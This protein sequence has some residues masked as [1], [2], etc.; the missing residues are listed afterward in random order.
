MPSTE[1]IEAFLTHKLSLL[2]DQREES[3]FRRNIV[4]SKISK[5]RTLEQFE[6]AGEM[7]EVSKDTK[8]IDTTKE[9][10]DPHALIQEFPNHTLIDGYSI[11]VQAYDSYSTST[12]QFEISLKTLKPQKVILLEPTLEFMRALE[13]YNAEQNLK[14]KLD[15]LKEPIEI[16][17]IRY[18]ESTEMYQ[19]MSVIEQEK[20]GFVELIDMKKKLFVELKDYKLEAEQKRIEETLKKQ[21]GGR[22][23]DA[24]QETKE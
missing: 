12:E 11:Y 18:E 15:H 3:Q 24:N 17:V 9:R 14:V 2:L 1:S 16:L 8:Q 4:T 21:A 6:G 20:R 22:K 7:A 10:E 23:G 5:K 19:H 13:I